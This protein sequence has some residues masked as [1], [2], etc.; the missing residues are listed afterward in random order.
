M[1]AELAR[2]VADP[3]AVRVVAV[4]TPEEL[5]VDETMETIERLREKFGR[6]P[7]LVVANAVF[8]AGDSGDPRSASS[9]HWGSG[10]DE[11]RREWEIELSRQAAELG[12]LARH[13]PGGPSARVD[14]P[15]V[16]AE[17]SPALLDG[18]EPALS[19]WLEARR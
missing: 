3:G 2:W 14:L 6:P 12:R 15:F 1:G 18:I 16:L 11:A 13:W 17:K 8:A 4:T 19:D 10:T 5:P 7:E 9:G